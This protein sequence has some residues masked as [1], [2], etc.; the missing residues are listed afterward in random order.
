MTTPTE[1]PD[2]VV[3]TM[4]WELGSDDLPSGRSGGSW[5]KWIGSIVGLAMVGAI[6]VAG[7]G[8]F[9]GERQAKGDE[10]LLTHVVTKGDFLATVTDE[11]TVESARNQDIR[12][13][14]AGGSTILSIIDDGKE[15]AEGAELARLDSSQ[16]EDQI[17]Q[18]KI[19]YEKARATHVQAQK[20]YE[21][22]KIAVQEYSEGTYPQSLEKASAD[23][24]IA[25]AN[26][27][28][29]QNSLD[30][31]KRIFEKGYSTQLQVDTQKLAVERA[32]LDL[33]AATTAKNVLERFTKAKTLKDLEGKR[34]TAEAK[35][36][37]EKAAL[38]LEEARLRRL[39]GQL[40][41]CVI[42]AP[43]AGMVVYANEQ[44]RMRFG[45]QQASEIKEG[46]TVR[47]QQAIFR[48]PDLTNMQVKAT[49]HESKVDRVR[50]GLRARIRIQ[51]RELQG[52]VVS[53][54]NQPEPPSFG[55][56]AKKY[57]TIIK[58]E[59]ETK[60]L[61][62][63]STAEVEILAA[64]LTDVVS[65]PV[66]AVFEDRG[67]TYAGVK[68]GT[69]IEKR[70]VEL[71]LS[72]DKSVEVKK[73]LQP[74]D[75]VVLN[76][77]LR[78]SDKVEEANDPKKVDV[79][80]RFGKGGPASADAKG[81]LD[82]NGKRPPD[83]PKGPGS[84]GSKGG[85]GGQGGREGKRGFDPMQ[86]DTNKDGKLSRDEAPP[87]LQDGFDQID[88]DKDGFITRAEMNAAMAKMRQGGGP[89]GRAPG[90]PPSP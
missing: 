39:E 19:V 8:F 74:G 80:K 49:I 71:G 75:V 62:P 10:Q 7:Y 30:Y 87:F 51:N 66:A 81:G 5:G 57:A 45:A 1:Q 61:R 33:K 52:T 77:R 12:C 23:I 36:N 67:Q 11:G 53:V 26:L 18:Q 17:N 55:S 68:K 76:V 88:A 13:E 38:D 84:Q 48:L 89:G 82:V 43:R 63:G 6:A 28:S 59:G 22:T 50:R 24:A 64:S 9:F 56:S 25:K 86:F 73:G 78:L 3:A 35:K 16:V 72:N 20:D 90:G 31:T 85:Q 79:E 83:G 27:T 46:A 4:T 69:E 2:D 32:E 34:D 44:A 14:M 60:D 47:E 65:V 15:V 37:A 21:V 70:P 41:K 58:I 40:K 29:A 42:V 54:A